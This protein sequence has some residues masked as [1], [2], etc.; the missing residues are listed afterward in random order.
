MVEHN[1][2]GASSLKNI[3][4][5]RQ[6]LSGHTA[7]VTALTW[8]RDGQ[9]LASGDQDGTICCWDWKTG[10][11]LY[12]NNGT[13]VGG[14]IW[15]L[16]WSPAGQYLAT[17]DL[18]GTT[19]L[20]DGKTGILQRVLS[21]HTGLAWSL[22]WSLDEQYLA[23]GSLDHTVCLWHAQ[24]GD[25][26]HRL[27]GHTAPVVTVAW[28]PEGQYLASGS[29]D[30]TVCIWH[31]QTG[32]LLKK[33][34][35]YGGPVKSL[36]WSS[37]GQVLTALSMTS[38][39]ES[40]EVETGSDLIPISIETESH[41][42]CWSPDRQVVA[43]EIVGHIIALFDLERSYSLEKGYIADTLESPTGPAKLLS[44]SSDGQFLT[45]FASP[46]PQQSQGVIHVWHKI[47]SAWLLESTIT[48]IPYRA[49]LAF[50]PD[51]KAIA[52]TAENSST[53]TLLKRDEAASSIDDMLSDTVIYKNAKVVLVG[54]TGVGKTGLALV[55]TGKPY[56][57]TDSTHGR[58][59]W[60]L[61]R[62]EHRDDRVVE[63]REIFLWDL[64][65]QPGYRLVHQ[66]HLDAVTLA[67]VVFDARNETEPFAG[68]LYWERALRQARSVQNTGDP[69]SPLKKFLVEARIDRGGVAVG[70]DRINELMQQ[71]GFAAHFKT[72]ARENI[73]IAVLR[74]AIEEAIV[75]EELRGV[76]STL[77]TQ[78][79][80]AFFV[81]QKEAGL[82]LG[83]IDALYLA[84][85]RTQR[86]LSKKDELFAHF[87]RG[88]DRLE[89]AGLIKRLSFGNLILLQPEI[90][91]MYASALINAAKEEPQGY[92][93]ITEER[94]RRGDFLIDKDLRLAD[95]EQ[96]R[97]LLIALIE[98]LLR[99]ELVLREE[100]FL[101]F[102][103][104]ST[105]QYPNLPEPGHK[106][107]VFTFDGPVMNIYVTLAVRLAN[108]GMFTRNELWK[109]AVTY[110][111]IVGG[112]CGIQ[113]HVDEDGHGEL[114]LF[115]H[116]AT[117][118]ETCLSFEL[119]IYNHLKLK[120]PDNLKR[121][122][123]FTCHNCKEVFSER[124]IQARI[125]RKF[126]W[127]NC[128]VCDTR[129]PL[130][131]KEKR[132]GTSSPLI[133]V[134]DNNAD[135]QRDQQ[136]NKSILEGKRASN[137]FDVFLWCS[138]EDKPTVKKY[139]RQLMEQGILP[140]LD[141]WEVQ[142]GL[143]QQSETE[144]YLKRAKSAAVFFGKGGIKAW[145]RLLEQ[146]FVREFVEGGRPL[147]PVI[148]P[149]AAEEMTLLNLPST[150]QMVRGVD[151]RLQDPDP[152]KQL[153][154]GITSIRPDL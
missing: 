8:S 89:L 9:Y 56:A 100:P 142:P 38:T 137:S 151:F 78:T 130:L 64:A 87:E 77:L 19:H 76:S 54:D 7:S 6:T 98:D 67:L 93:S 22:T 112:E 127:L 15:D 37:S 122:R 29:F 30:Q 85:L 43:I 115:F 99:R 94:V 3:Y 10:A 102:P 13:S 111:A 114:A 42:F 123:I 90:L 135:R 132:L 20:W 107:V 45:S 139:G 145:I 119:Y 150:F 24:T 106:T 88:I 74:T 2:P 47:A 121:Q 113:L 51:M 26:L 66:L 35:C 138:Y 103:S 134:M 125:A 110:T 118:E 34:S 44:F 141:D 14:P 57:A 109:N 1:G 53:I 4:T 60:T 16:V 149:E 79:I 27:T 154:W 65:G 36:V 81:E 117:T 18:G 12:T 82:L 72:S 46:D 128:P 86:N 148:L 32:D 73:A 59:V 152:F 144:K 17:S 136:A 61:S 21:G 62:K 5:I 92:G 129:V 140:W 28:S 69:A 49:R 63:I 104:Q 50:H 133:Q 96:E 75:W 146:A 83:T 91:D 120:A 23:S 68:V 41:A 48:D 95:K 52:F 33:F 70:T 84:F 131:D 153:V 97:L 105:R 143:P 25:L 116:E 80:R 101:L 71:Y 147:I 126:D 11:L 124:T 108:S 55:L 31:T 39:I 58:H 40:W